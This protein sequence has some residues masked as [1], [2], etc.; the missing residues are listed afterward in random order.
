[1][2]LQ[3]IHQKPNEASGSCPFRRYP[4]AS[5]SISLEVW[6]IGIAASVHHAVPALIFTLELLA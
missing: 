5:A 6:R 3:Q 2:D 4:D 1:M